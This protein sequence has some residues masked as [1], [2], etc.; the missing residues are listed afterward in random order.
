V[1]EESRHQNLIAASTLEQLRSRHIDDSLQLRP[2]LKPGTVLDI[3]SGAGFPGLALACLGSHYV[4]LVEPRTRR[5]EFLKSAIIALDISESVEVHQS[6][7]QAVR[8]VSADNVVARAVASLDK[9]FEMGRHLTH[10][11]SRWVLPKGRSAQT[12]L[13]AVRQSWQGDFKLIASTTDPSS[14]IVVAENVRRRR[15]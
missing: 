9:L 14:S 2:L 13:E 8:D 6:T 3:G 15:A 7:V 1:L 5:A 10:P 11:G 4:H 12:E